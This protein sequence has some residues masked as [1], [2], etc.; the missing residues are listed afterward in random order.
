MK[1][2]FILLHTL[3]SNSIIIDCKIYVNSSKITN[4]YYGNDKIKT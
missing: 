3:M 4:M 2:G 1:T